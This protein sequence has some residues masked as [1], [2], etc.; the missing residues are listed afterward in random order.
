MSG[1]VLQINIS[2]GGLPKR[3]VDRARVT[4]FGIEG[5]SCA[6]PAVHG[7]PRKAILL[8]ASEMVAELIEAGYPLYYG[9]LGENIT[10]S[11]IDPKWMRAGQR[12]RIGQ[13]LI[14]LTTLRGPCDA[15]NVFGKSLRFEITDAAAKA[16]DFHSPKWA[17]G[18]FYAA[19]L[20]TGEIC[21]GDPI[22]LIEQLA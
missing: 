16:G 7:G 1:A 4:P 21:T 19:V 8:V 3:P 22:T 6:H 5:D 10:M 14:E 15:L 9:A 18:G 17:R 11:G 12:Y 20:E 2:P 13:V